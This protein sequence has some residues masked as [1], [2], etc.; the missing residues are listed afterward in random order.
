MPQDINIDFR[1][2]KVVKREHTDEK[3]AVFVFSER[4]L[5]ALRGVNEPLPG[6]EVVKGEVEL[7][8]NAKVST[9]GGSSPFIA[10]C[11]ECGAEYEIG[12]K[13]AS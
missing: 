7:Y 11:P 1:C 2:R 4:Q 13:D 5:E 10:S 9:Y 6:P 3:P 12:V 8:C